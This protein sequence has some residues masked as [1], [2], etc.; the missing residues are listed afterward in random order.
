M[1]R[2]DLGPE[3]LQ[4]PSWRHVDSDVTR[5]TRTVRS[6]SFYRAAR[7]G[8]AL[9]TTGERSFDGKRIEWTTVTS[10][11]RKP[12]YNPLQVSCNRRRFRN[13]N[14]L[15]LRIMKLNVAF[16][17]VCANE[18]QLVQR[19]SFI[20][21]KC[22]SHFT[23]EWSWSGCFD[24]WKKTVYSSSLSWDIVRALFAYVRSTGQ[25]PLPIIIHRFYVRMIGIVI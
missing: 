12:I 4:R 18:L 5:V 14:L 10:F 16:L 23:A 6:G 19:I 9:L 11:N 3:R 1:T 24:A 22:A 2:H 13:C 15:F 21:V 7:R 20:W 17:V 25:F 8:V